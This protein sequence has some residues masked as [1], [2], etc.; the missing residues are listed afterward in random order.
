M[1]SCFSL[2]EQK[3]KGVVGEG[4]RENPVRV[5]ELHSLCVKQGVTVKEAAACCESSPQQCCVFWGVKPCELP[6]WPGRT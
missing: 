3:Q 2:Y 4:E 6:N 5:I 1:P